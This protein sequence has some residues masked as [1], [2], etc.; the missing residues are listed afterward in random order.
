MADTDDIF[1]LE[2]KENP[3][4]APC[5]KEVTMTM[6]S[7]DEYASFFSS[8]TTGIKWAVQRLKDGNAKLIRKEITEIKNEKYL[9]GIQI[10]IPIS[11]FSF[12]AKKRKSPSIGSCFSIKQMTEEQIKKL[13]GLKT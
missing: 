6:N 12:K 13:E 8:H 11:Y 3:N 4:R 5:E 10:Y 2:I 1:D 7:Y 9:T